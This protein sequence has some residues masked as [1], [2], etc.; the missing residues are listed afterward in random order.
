[1]GSLL[2][3]LSTTA[4][5]NFWQPNSDSTEQ[6]V[7]LTQPDRSLMCTGDA[8]QAAGLGQ[9]ITC[10]KLAQLIAP[11]ALSYS[12]KVYCQSR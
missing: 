12:H 1:M 3:R 6:R 9:G 5:S 8:D 10:T 4:E 11:K 7:H 2:V